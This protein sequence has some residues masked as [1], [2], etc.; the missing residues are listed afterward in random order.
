MVCSCIGSLSRLKNMPKAGALGAIADRNNQS[1]TLL[2]FAFMMDAVGLKSTAP[3][4]H[5]VGFVPLTPVCTPIR[6]GVLLCGI[7]GFY[8]EISTN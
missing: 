3:C 7:S 2:H 6:T 1:V 4:S 5:C 8:S